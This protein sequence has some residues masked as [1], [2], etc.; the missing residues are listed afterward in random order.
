M[1]INAHTY[2]PMDE[3][4]RRAVNRIAKSKG[5]AVTRAPDTAEGRRLMAC[6]K[7]EL[8]AQAAPKAP[9][10]ARTVKAPKA[11]AKPKAPKSALGADGIKRTHVEARKAAWAWRL[12]EFHAERKHTY[13][14]ACATFGTAPANAG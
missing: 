14:A 9:T 2:T 5:L 4:D 7:V 10:K 11:A 1:T 13:A 12:A 3:L 8:L 6:S